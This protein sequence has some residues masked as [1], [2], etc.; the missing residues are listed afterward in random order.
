MKINH[1]LDSYIEK[2]IV[3]IVFLAILLH[4]KIKIKSHVFVCFLFIYL[5]HYKFLKFNLVSAILIL[6]IESAMVFA[7]NCHNLCD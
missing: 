7:F 1:N 6:P 2:A 3:L 5:F 4:S